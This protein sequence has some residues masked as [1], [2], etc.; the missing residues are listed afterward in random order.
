MVFQTV[1]A[2]FSNLEISM[3]IVNVE[4]A[5]QIQ[6]GPRRFAYFKHDHK[7]LVM[8]PIPM[9]NVIH[10]VFITDTTKVSTE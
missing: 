7:L 9:C 10:G 6:L 2:N 3:S 1:L 4:D 8:Q 5:K